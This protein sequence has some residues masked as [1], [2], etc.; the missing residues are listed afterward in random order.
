MLDDELL[1]G[2]P[3]SYLPGAIAGMHA[4]ARN[5]FYFPS[6]KYGIQPDVRDGMAASY[7]DPARP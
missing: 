6:P 5:G 2:L 1:W 7:P 4:L 3:P